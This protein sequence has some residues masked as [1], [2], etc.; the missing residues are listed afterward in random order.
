[1]SLEALKI[2]LEEFQPISSTDG[3]VST[4]ELEAERVIQ[5]FEGKIP[6]GNKTGFD[7]LDRYFRIKR[8]NLV[9]MNGHDNVG[10]SFIGWYLILITVIINKERW[11]M[12]CGENQSADIRVQLVEFACGCLSNRIPKETFDYWLDFMYKKFEIIEISDDKEE[13]ETVDTII[14]IASLIIDESDEEFHGLFIDPYNALELDLSGFDGRLSTHDYHYSCANKFRRFKKNK[15]ISL[16]VS[17]HAVS[18]A[19]RKVD[20]D[21]YPLPPGKADTEG[22]G[23]FANKA[24]EF[25]TWHRYVQDSSRSRD[26]EC[27]I[28]KVKDTKTGGKCTDLNNPVILHWECHNGFHGFYDDEGNCPLAPNKKPDIPPLEK[29]PEA[30]NNFE[31]ESNPF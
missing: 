3:Y 22:G 14:R 5:S 28:R 15:N 18:Q 16:W 23:K 9:I 25:I 11:I 7:V 31:N 26:T 17:M 29:F 4:R 21:G 27:H 12:F 10:K 24:D 19:L 20:S 6:Q 30:P 13:L 2:D 8:G 1:M